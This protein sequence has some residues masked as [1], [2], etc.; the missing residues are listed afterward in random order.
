MEL[1]VAEALK[2]V[3]EPFA[4]SVCER[5]SPQP[6]DR[7]S[8]EFASDVRVSGTYVFDGTGF[9]LDAVAETALVEQCARCLCTFTR[10]MRFPVRERF[11]KASEPESDD[12]YPFMGSTLDIT[13][14]VL[15]NLFLNMPI[16]SVCREDCKGLCPVCGID[17]NAAQCSCQP[18]RQAGP[19]AALAGLSDKE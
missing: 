10:E 13:R 18:N 1:Q 5:F 6:Y 9:S 16:T 7:R 19:F 2:R 3:G 14:A 17:R 15:D 8:V 12:M 11:M 4:F